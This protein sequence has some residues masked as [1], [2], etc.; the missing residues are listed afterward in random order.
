[1]DRV[2][3]DLPRIEVG[4]EQVEVLPGLSPEF[5]NEISPKALRRLISIR[6]GAKTVQQ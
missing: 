2:Q 5:R 3:I 6:R 1:L 4:R